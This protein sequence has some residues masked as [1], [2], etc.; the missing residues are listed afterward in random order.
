[1]AFG[2]NEDF[3]KY[4]L[5][6]LQGVQ[7]E[8]KATS[9]TSANVYYIP[10]TP[11]QNRRYVVTN[12]MKIS[13]NSMPL[14]PIPGYNFNLTHKH[15]GLPSTATLGGVYRF[16]YSAGGVSPT[17][18]VTVYWSDPSFKPSDYDVVNVHIW[19][20]GLNYRGE[21]SGYNED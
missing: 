11:E 4:P 13:G 14:E 3:T 21:A 20:D 19:Y 17:Q 2:F 12:Y 1:M 7:S 16:T 10:G 9:E 8:V 15:G 5:D 18:E 6:G